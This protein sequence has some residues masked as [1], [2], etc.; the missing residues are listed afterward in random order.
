MVFKI[1]HETWR[2]SLKKRGTRQV[3]T[4]LSLLLYYDQD[5]SYV[6]PI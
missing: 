4:Q 3:E 2:D 1:S 6:D 5:D